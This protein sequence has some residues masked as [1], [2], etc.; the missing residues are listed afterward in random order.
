MGRIL[1]DSDRKD[2]AVRAFRNGMEILRELSNELP[3]EHVQKY[4]SDP[5]KQRLRRALSRS[6]AALEVPVP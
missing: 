4:L 2:E 1:W 5:D 3:A 6:I